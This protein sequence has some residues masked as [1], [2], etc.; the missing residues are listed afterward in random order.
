MND[1]RINGHRRT[2]LG[3]AATGMV[4][5]AAGRVRAGARPTITVW[6]D[7]NCGCCGGWVEHLRRNSFVAT[8]HETADVQSVKRQLGVPAALAS[9]HTAEIGGYA[10][11]GH[12]PAREVRRLLKE[13]PAAVGIAAPGMPLGSPGM[14]TPEYGGR[15]TPYDVLLVRRDGSSSVYQSYRS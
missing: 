2:F 4:L 3:M 10:I 6:K 5:L 1:R 7:P 8:V 14:D 12:V 9:C 11:E 13:K 15:K